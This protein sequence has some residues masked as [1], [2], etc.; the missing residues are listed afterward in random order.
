MYLNLASATDVINR[1]FWGIYHMFNPAF[2]IFAI[3]VAFPV[4]WALTYHMGRAG[5]PKDLFDRVVVGPIWI[6][7]AAIFFFIG[8]LDMFWAN[9]LSGIAIIGSLARSIWEYGLR[10]QEKVMIED[11]VKALS[12]PSERV[13]R[14]PVI[15]VIP[16]Y[17][18]EAA[19]FDLP[20]HELQ[21]VHAS[22]VNHMRPQL[23]PL[24]W[25]GTN[26]DTTA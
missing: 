26:V 18:S 5:Y 9:L 16:H 22:C 13:R 15:T 8:G 14:E 10:C 21:E 11:A 25:A 6:A 4:G 17:A 2:E 19:D 12:T 20:R 1:T 23:P 24:A 7:I 3:L